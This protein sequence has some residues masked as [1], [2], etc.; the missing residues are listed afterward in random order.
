MSQLVILTKYTEVSPVVIVGGGGKKAREAKARLQ[1]QRVKAKTTARKEYLVA[2]ATPDSLKLN[3]V[4]ARIQGVA[5]IPAQSAHRVRSKSSALRLPSPAVPP[6]ENSN[7]HADRFAPRV[8][9]PRIP[10][11]AS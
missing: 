3:P 2:S 5:L 11:P 4:S 10:R 1:L 8:W 9:A 6:D 7:T